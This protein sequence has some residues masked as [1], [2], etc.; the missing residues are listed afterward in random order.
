MDD[1]TLTFEPDEAIVFEAEEPKAGRVT[2]LRAVRQECLDC[3]GG[4]ANEVRLCVSKSCPSWPFRF[5]RRPTAELKAEV[6]DVL[7][8]P[9]ERGI[10]G[11]E[12]HENGGTALHAIKLKCLDCSGYNRAEVKVCT[13]RSCALHPFRFGKATR[14]YSDEVR[15]KK[16][17]LARALAAKRRSLPEND[18]R[19]SDPEANS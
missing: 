18:D 17:E 15:A 13:F 5:G 16:A 3:C 6:A 4:S 19:A 8:H 7:L 10:T 12:F 1:T 2:P 11:K 9:A 14:N